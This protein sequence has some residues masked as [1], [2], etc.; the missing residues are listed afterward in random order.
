M[1]IFYCN[2]RGLKSKTTSLET[3]LDQTKPDIILI[4][5]TQVIGRCKIKIQNYIINGE[6]NRNNKSGGILIGTRKNSDIE[7]VILKKD[8]K[9][10]QIWAIIRTKTYS[11]RVCLVYGYPSEHRITPEELEEWYVVLE[12]EYMKQMEYDTMI[13][14]DFNA[15]T[16]TDGMPMNS[17]GKNLNALVER[18][19]LINMNNQSTC[20]GKFTREDKNGTKTIIDYVIADQNMQNKIKEVY[21]DDQHKYKMHRYRKVHEKSEEI[22]TDHNPILIKLEIEIGNKKEKITR[23]NFNSEKCLK[24]FKKETTNINM[25]EQ[26]NNEGDI[27]NKYRKWEKQITGLMY[28]C[29]DRITIKDKPTNNEVKDLINIKRKLNQKICQIQTLS[30]KSNIVINRLKQR[31]TDLIEE[32]T[33]KINLNRGKRNK[34]K[35][36]EMAKGAIK[37]EIWQIRKQNVTKSDTKHAVKDMKGNLITTKENILLRYQEYYSDLLQNRK[38]PQEYQNHSKLIDE[39]FQNRMKITKYD[40]L[41]I[42]QEF[43]ESELNKAIRTMKTG[44]A[45]GPD[46]V[47]YEL[48][49]NSG[50]NLKKNLLK[51]IN[52]FWMKENIPTKLK[53]LYIKSMYKGKG[54][55]CELENQRGLF[56]SSNIIKTYE[57][58]IYNRT[59]PKTESEGFSKYQCGGRKYHS[60]TDQVFIIRTLQEYYAYRGKNYFIEFCDLQKAFDKMILKNVMDNLWNAEA[61]GR[62]W[63]NIY[64]INKTTDAIIK[65]PY[66][67]TEKIHITEILKQGSVLASTLAALHTDSSTRLK[68]EEL[69]ARYGDIYIHSLLFQDDIARIETNAE[70]LNAANKIY[71][72]FQDLN[73]MMFH[74]LKTVFISNTQKKDIKLNNNQIKQVKSTKY[75]GD[76]ISDNGKLDENIEDRRLKVNGVVA[77][78]RSI[79][80]E[81][82][83][84]LEIQAAIQYYEGIVKTKLLYN[85]ETWINMNKTNIDELEKIQN[86]SLKRLL[87]IPFSTP[88][89]GLLY[90]LKLL[91]IKASINQRKLMY[92]HKLTNAEKSLASSILKQQESIQ[93]N[94]FLKE[95]KQNLQYYNINYDINEIKEMSKENWKKQVHTAIAEIDTLEIKEHCRNSSKCRNLTNTTD[96]RDYI[97]QIDSKSAKI[98]LLEKLNMTDVKTNYKGS[99]TSYECRLCGKEREDTTHLLNC[100]ELGEID[101]N[102]NEIHRELSENRSAMLPDNLKSLAKHILLKV[103][104][105]DKLVSNTASGPS[106]DEDNH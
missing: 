37:D 103:S 71:E 17:N 31:K 78:I 50:T 61:K 35:M 89:M 5:E 95:I 12:E 6:A 68:E 8:P 34:M 25:K 104:K 81:A 39:T 19:N 82:E 24:Q 74:K 87:R 106:I 65:T 102:L 10:Q 85:C 83:E 92:F 93:S 42:N 16:G 49:I 79:M 77:E 75:L 26:W 97:D 21:I 29:F 101:T 52:Y 30:L 47:T 91:T 28:K 14:G 15:H 3:V 59:Y 84:D 69:G 23:W 33:T 105:R 55:I 18:R 63:R 76:I 57:K 58:M 11:L 22:A 73:G 98:I 38:I 60:P 96:N 90:E 80:M 43:S 45:P 72:I 1:K 7:T 41:P 67:E 62:I 88:S 99:Y 32:I 48:I 100:T 70:K 94:H 36:N 86:N 4:A 27:D 46:Q 13:I 44:K 54:D 64:E 9:N 20:K 66:G 40:N 2:I 53:T 56:L 51:M